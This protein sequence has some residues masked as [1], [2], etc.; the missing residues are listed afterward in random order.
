MIQD[1]LEDLVEEEDIE[2]LEKLIDSKVASLDIRENPQSV[3]WNMLVQMRRMLAGRTK[4]SNAT[5]GAKTDGAKFSDCEDLNEDDEAEKA[6]PLISRFKEHLQKLRESS[7]GT[8]LKH[9]SLC[10]K[11]S[12]TPEDPMVTSCLHIYCRECLVTLMHKAAQNGQEN[13]SC[14]KCGYAFPEVVEC[15]DI[16]DFGFNDGFNS[17]Q[18]TNRRKRRRR[19]LSPDESFRWLDFGGKLIQS[20]KTSAMF[21]KIEAWQK[22]E[23]DIKIIIFTQFL[24]MSVC[25][26]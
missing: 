23:P 9:H 19:A 12:D 25:S 20:A 8:A 26:K 6:H 24:S 5:S 4:L 3:S 10:H 1:T 21:A 7:N 11:C 14:L 2:K 13:A 18:A 15:N 17:S 16:K 22:E